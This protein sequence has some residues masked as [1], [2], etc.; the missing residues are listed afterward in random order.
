MNRQDKLA[1]VLPSLHEA[2]LD[3]AL[4]P[5][6]SGRID[7][8]CGLRG[9]A[10]VMA[11]GQSQ[12]DLDILFARI[13]HHGDRDEDWERTY[14]GD[15]YPL[16]ERVPRLT[17]LRD[18][19]LVRIGDLY[20]EHER[21]SSAT[22]NEPLARAGY[23]N[24]LNVRLDGPQGASIYWVLADSTRRGG[25]GSRQIKVIESLLPHLRHFLQVR[26]ALGGAQALSDTLSGLLD[27]SRLGVIQLDRR[28]RVIEAN[29][30]ARRL[31]RRGHGLFERG[32]NLHARALADDTR[33][34]GLVADA[35]PRFG[36]QGS[37]GG[38]TVSR[39]P[40]RLRQAVHALP[41]TCREKDFG[42]GRV[43][44]LVLVVEPGSPVRLDAELVA[45]VLGLTKTE[46][47]VAVA[48]AT[49]KTVSAI[50][51]ERGQKVSTTR[52][53]VK[54]IHAKLGLSRQPDLIRLLLTL[55]DAP[56][57]RR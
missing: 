18:S 11:R 48:L 19:D 10:L 2:A 26:H 57:S 5:V 41:V 50:A 43:A 45:S 35:L 28:G 49:G 7:E 44:V 51:K 4:W 40:S 42:I 6:A 52:Y 15:Y 39:W 29:D 30:C 9:N 27:D 56:G 14:F 34:Q 25:W 36:R 20:T 46:S 38:V 37:G 47:Q 24:G 17:Q 16:D 13:C 31:L 32:G 1:G 21:K 3:D 54:E 22:Y 33:L 23:Q 55:G 8:A 12:V 53:H